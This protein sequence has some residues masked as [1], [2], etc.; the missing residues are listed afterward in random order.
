ME[1]ASGI[2][3]TFGGPAPKRFKTEHADRVF[4]VKMKCAKDEA[5]IPT[6]GSDGAA[7]LDVYVLGTTVLHPG[8]T[9]RFQ[10]GVRVGIPKGF[11]GRMAD[12]SGNALKGIRITGVIDS[13]Y[14]GELM[15]I[16]VNV[17]PL[18]I[19]INHHDRLAQLIIEPCLM[20]DPMELNEWPRDLETARGANGFGSTGN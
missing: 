19:Q 2:I 16:A 17:S 15:V 11:Y 7:G 18:P 14:T 1:P 20:T 6:R 4:F 8:I 10:T 9:Q 5:V 13:D 12:R 3:D